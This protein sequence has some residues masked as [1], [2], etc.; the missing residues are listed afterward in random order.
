LWFLIQSSIIFAVIAS[1]IHW[2]WTPNT[3][4][5]GRP[6]QAAPGRPARVGP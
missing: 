6:R 3:Y 4:L 2:H 5:A 1:N